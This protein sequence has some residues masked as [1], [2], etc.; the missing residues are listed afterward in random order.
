VIYCEHYRE[1][2]N[3]DDPTAPVDASALCGKPAV[4]LALLGPDENGNQIA[5]GLCVEHALED[6]YEIWTTIWIEDILRIADGIRELGWKK[7][8]GRQAFQRAM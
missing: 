4:A 6:N 1:D 5:S 2:E 8:R 7:P 3:D